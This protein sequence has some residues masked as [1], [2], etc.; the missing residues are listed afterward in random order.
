[1]CKVFTA[2]SAVINPAGT[3]VGIGDSTSTLFQYQVGDDGTMGDNQDF[4]LPPKGGYVIQAIEPRVNAWHNEPRTGTADPTIVDTYE[5]IHNVSATT[6][7]GTS[8]AMDSLDL[9]TDGLFLVGGDTAPAGTFADFVDADE[10]AGLT[11]AGRAGIWSSNAAGTIAFLTNYIGR[12][13][14]GTTTLTEFDDSGFNVIFPG[15]FVSDGQNGLFFDLGNASTIITLTD[16]TIS[17]SDR[18]FGGRSR[19][20]RY[21]DTEFDVTGGATD[22]IAITAHGFRTG[23]A[24]IYNANGGT[25]DIGPDATNGEAEF[26]SAAG[27][28][29]GAY[30][31]VIRVDA[32]NFQ[33][34]ATASNAFAA[35]PT[36]T[37]L[38]ASTA[39][40][41]ERHILTRAPD[42]RPNIEFNGT[43]GTATLTRVN[44]TQTRIITLTSAVT[45]TG[46]I[47]TFGQSLVLGDGT[48]N[49]CTITTPDTGIDESYMTATNAVDLDNIDNTTFSAGRYGHAIEITTDGTTTPNN[50]ASL[51][52]VTFNDYFT[53]DE[54]GTGGVS[55]NASTGVA[56]NQI[57]V[58]P[59]AHN[60]TTGDPVFYEDEGGTALTGLTDG[61]LYFVEVVDADTVYLHDTEASAA[62]GASGNRLTITAG[63]SET[64]KLYHGQAAIH[65]STGA[66]VTINISGGSVPSIRNSNGSTTSVVATTQVTLTGLV[67]NTEVR[68]YTQGTTT[69]LAGQENVTTGTFSFSLSSGTIVDIRVFAVAYEPADILNFTVPASDT[70]IPVQQRFD[71]NYENP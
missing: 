31:Y 37:G 7:A 65:N 21:F 49:G 46:C 60:F 13:D 45:L 40:N 55:F 12:T 64:H 11:G 56:S 28:G 18:R 6:G 20:V 62:L 41:G 39:G 53:G 15:G 51:S 63:S 8:Q 47:I 69:E 14:A 29:T 34:A 27:I 57:T 5:L 32:D 33:L 19:I 59:A 23:D 3:E 58:T 36:A 17:G 2:L 43:A 44:L 66:A 50:T 1:M 24:V 4:I 25:E 22:Q 35:T 54:D 52:G 48:L 71:R 68:V 61:A 16:G 38:T 70:S 30:W 67:N 26:N 42:T 10:G 9:T